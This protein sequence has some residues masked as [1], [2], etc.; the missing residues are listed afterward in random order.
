MANVSSSNTTTLYSTTQQTVIQPGAA[1]ATGQVNDANFTT[2]YTSGQQ[3]NPNANLVVDGTLTVNGCAI[4]TNCTSFNLLPTTAT[5]INFGLEATALSIGSGSGTTTINNQL[6]TANYTFPVADGL[7]GQVLVT[8]GAGQLSF[9][10]ASGIGKTYDIS[11]STTTGGAD[12]NLNSNLPTTDTVKFAA[13]SGITVVATDANTITITNSDPGSAG[14]TS[15]TG[16]TNQIIASAST[17]AVTLSTP[18]DIAT[19]SNV[20]FASV[21]TSGDIAVNGG[22]ITTTA[23]TFNLLNTTATTVNEFGAANTVNRGY[24]SPTNLAL[25]T[26]NNI[27][28]NLTSIKYNTTTNTIFNP[29]RLR[30]QAGTGITPA[31]NFGVGQLYL[32]DNN[33]AVQQTA[34]SH[35]VVWTNATSANE[36]A[37]FRLSLLNRAFAA[38]QQTKLEVNAAGMLTTFA[39][40][41]TTNNTATGLT[42]QADCSGTPT[43]GFG[44]NWNT[45]LETPASGYVI[46][47]FNDVTFTDV[48]AGAE[49]TQ[50][51]VGLRDGSG[52]AAVKLTLDSTGLLTSRGG[53]QTNGSSSGYSRFTAPAT[54][55]NIDYVLPNAQGAASTVLTN[56]GA[57]NLSWALPGGGGSTFGNI[58]IAIVD[59]NTIS[60][61]TGDLILD[62]AT[63]LVK[64]TADLSVDNNLTVNADQ[65]GTAT[66][67]AYGNTTANTITYNGS[68]WQINDSTRIVASTS[69]T[70]TGVLVADLRAISTG[71]TT[72]GFGPSLNFTAQNGAPGNLQNSGFI[73]LL[74]TDVTAGV[75]DTEMSFAVLSNGT[76]TRVADLDSNGLLTTTGGL[77]TNGS[78]SGYSR[79]TAPA[80]GAN[81]NYVLPN[82][83]GAANT[84]L[85]ND[86]AGNLT[87]ALPG[88]GGSTF[89][90][91][92]IGVVTDNTISTT[93]GNL[94]LDAA[95]NIVQID[96][97]QLFIPFNSNINMENNYLID[98]ASLTTSTTAAN[99]VLANMNSGVTRSAKFVVQITSG[100]AYQI[101]EIL[102]IHDGT[103]ATITVYGDVRTGANLAAFDADVSG[104]NF[105]LL[106]TPVNAITDYKVAITRMSV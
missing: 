43:V 56:D 51:R 59:D 104:G 15:I 72:V 68:D 37:A 80:T 82:A 78:S 24:S 55:A 26:N 44:A 88:G 79:F 32:L 89:G 13:G 105:R 20:N 29:L 53:L 92:S 102:G 1:V 67:T 7:N 74:F 85:T 54:G 3:V 42:L 61:T 77:Q 12:F 84:V 39:I 19:T 73:D 4:L 11:A 96:A 34:G 98:S 18:Q 60:T 6:A 97:D 5:S 22:D 30:S 27:N 76:L 8:N 36:Q 93:T 106:T 35:G 75:E 33:L 83:Q 63:N 69:N 25:L 57:G 38:S 21:T 40:T 28:G 47:S 101:V 64:V 31:A 70:N 16:T 99:Q 58:T 41:S 46:G 90:N 66:I 45:N 86:G 48:T 14:V 17:G 10:A 9:A 65:T 100:T 95:S 81:I 23:A 62:S 49:K 50:W 103:T 52:S 2:L 91:V 94:I 87:W 71:T